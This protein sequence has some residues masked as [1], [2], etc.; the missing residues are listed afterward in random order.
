MRDHISNPNA[1]HESSAEVAE[2]YLSVSPETLPDG[3]KVLTTDCEG[4]KAFKALPAALKFNGEL[5]GKTGWNSDK[6][7]AYYR[8]D[9]QLAKV[10]PGK[11]TE[12]C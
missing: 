10:V 11:T 2:G 6:H 7:I 12:G 5:Y 4:Y 8:T 3:V 1:H 9:A